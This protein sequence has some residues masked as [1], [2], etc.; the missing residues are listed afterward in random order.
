MTDGAA[1]V[2]ELS[3]FQRAGAAS[4]GA[5]LTALTV[6]PFDVVKTRMQVAAAHAASSSAAAAAVPST[7]AGCAAASYARFVARDAG[8]LATCPRCGFWVLNDGLME[9]TLAK[10]DAAQLFRETAEAIFLRGLCVFSSRD[11]SVQGESA[12][13][14]A[15]KTVLGTLSRIA[16]NE[17]VGGL[18]A[19]LTPTVV[20]AVPNTVLYFTAYEEIHGWMKER[21]RNDAQPEV[22]PALAPALSGTI[23][24][25][26]A[27]TVVSPFELARTQLQA[28]DLARRG[29]YF[30][31]LRGI[32]RAEGVVGLWRGL[33]PTLWRDVPYDAASWESR[34]D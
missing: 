24:R 21:R 13:R 1:A 15:R 19:G 20:M 31:S 8:A 12:L 18:Y 5:M 30:E 27:A 34:K 29:E 6:T 23:A 11:V 22:P 26:V 10:D 3:L 9:H 7:T 14:P 4:A 16:R 17:G 28:M 32:I 25:V 2:R 33:A